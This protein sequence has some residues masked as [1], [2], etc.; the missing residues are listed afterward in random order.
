MPTTIFYTIADADNDQSVISI[1][2]NFLDTLEG[3]SLAFAVEYGWDIINP[4][5]NG[6]LVNCGITIQVDIADFTNSA[7]AAISDVQEKAEFVYR[8]VGGFIKRITL[9]TFIETFFTG[10]GAG[11]EVDVTQSEVAAF[12]TLMVDGFHEALVSTEPLNPVTDHNEDITSFV[13][14]HQ[15]WGKNRR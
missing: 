11:K 15:A 14:G 5:I 8:A 7:A 12:N 1:P 3:A 4:L 6:T 2:V 10:S 13:E 9:P